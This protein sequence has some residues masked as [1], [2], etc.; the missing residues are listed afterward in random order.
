MSSENIASPVTEFHIENE[1]VAQLTPNDHILGYFLRA[2]LS[3]A[4]S[5]A[6]ISSDIEQ[7]RNKIGILQSLGVS[8]KQLLKRQ[9]YIGLAVSG[10]AV[11]AANVLLWGFIALYALLSDAVLGNLLWGY[12]WLLHIG[13]CIFLAAIITA[14]YV[15]PMHGI[16]RYL[17]IENIKTRK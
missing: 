1:K 11:F 6:S 2:L 5:S 15:A 10:A 8:N 17:P 16:R 9:L 14:L 3:D 12:P 7:E 4:R 13:A